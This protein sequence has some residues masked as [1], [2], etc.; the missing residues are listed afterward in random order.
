ML[1]QK[2]LFSVKVFINHTPEKQ[3]NSKH[4]REKFF[5]FYSKANHITIIGAHIEFYSDSFK[6]AGWKR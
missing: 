3:R 2:E 4:V 1:Q 5:F 6:I